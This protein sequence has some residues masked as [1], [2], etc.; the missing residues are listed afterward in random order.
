M[1][2]PERKNM[3]L[4]NLSAA[5]FSEVRKVRC[6]HY[7][8]HI[9]NWT[10]LI[11]DIEKLQPSSIFVLTDKNSEKHCLHL[12]LERVPV[13]FSVILIPEGEEHKHLETCQHIW[14]NLMEKG[15][16]RKSLLINLGGGVIGDI[17]G[18]CAATYMRGIPFIQIPTTLLSQVDASIG[19]KLGID[20]HQLKN[21]IGVI[22]PPH[23]VHIMTGFL[24]SLPEREMRSG[25]AEMLKHGLIASSEIWQR[26]AAKMPSDSL[27]WGREVIASIKIKKS[28][29]EQDPLEKG[30]R[31]I[32]NFGHTIGHAIESRWLSAP[33][34]LL[35]GEAI[36]IGMICE[37]YISYSKGLLSEEELFEIR[38]SL[39]Q[40]FGHHPKAVNG[41][42]DIIQLMRSDKKN[43]KGIIRMALLDGIGAAVFN[44]PVE[45]QLIRESLMFY[46]EKL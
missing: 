8:I 45:E 44:Q 9:N 30:I 32:L 4:F 5:T 18:F 20:L 37:A 33:Q 17:G 42:E 12:F 6:K 38:S 15:A 43:E 46:R 41:S 2:E 25:Y 35:H 14:T 27:E 3:L 23:A 40:H 1:T 13:P 39:V 36:A 31:K 19:G 24:S 21:M 34:R 10:A 11:Q 29:T 16:D 7:D 28:I 22:Q 26:L